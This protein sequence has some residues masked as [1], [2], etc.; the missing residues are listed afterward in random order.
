VRAAVIESVALVERLVT[1]PDFAEGVSAFVEKR[2][3]QW[4]KHKKGMAW[5]LLTHKKWARL[6]LRKESLV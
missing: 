1:E 3:P 5:T 4:G 2:P 6:T